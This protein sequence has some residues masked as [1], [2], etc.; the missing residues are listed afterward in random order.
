MLLQIAA[1]VPLLLHTEPMLADGGT[2]EV[3]AARPTSSAAESV[4]ERDVIDAAPRGGGAVDVLRLV[5]GLVAS[6]HSGDG[7][8]HQLFLRGFDA[9]HGQDVEL[10]AAGMP[11]NAVSHLHA[12]GYA[13]A[14]FLIPEAVQRVRVTEGTYR[15]FQGDFA[16]AGT[17]SFE[18]GLSEPGAFA[19][20]T[21]GTYGQRRLLL[22]ARAP[23]DPG[24]FIAAEVSQT[25]GYGERRG[26]R[27]YSAMAQGK[28]RF[29]AVTLRG[30][31]GSYQSEFESP[32]VVRATELEAGRAG[33]FDARFDFQ[34]GRTARHQGL[35]GAD[36][37]IAGGRTSLELCGAY[38][39]DVIRN[40]FTG[41]LAHP[42]GDGREQ[43]H[44]AGTAVLRL[45]HHR[46][47]QLLGASLSIDGS[48]GARGD[49]A[50]QLQHRYRESDGAPADPQ[51]DARFRQGDAWGWLEFKY[52]PGAWELFLGGRL[53][54]LGFAVDD[55]LAVKG[56]G[57]RR[58]SLGVHPGL[59]AGLSR[60]FG[61][62]LRLLANYGDGFRSPQALSLGEGERAPFVTARSAELGAQWRSERLDANLTAFGSYVDDDV[63]FDPALGTTA[64][65]GPSW[66]AGGTASVV[67]RPVGE[68]VIA[69]SITGATARR[70]RPDS[71]LPYFAPLVARADVGDGLQVAPWLHLRGGLGLTLIG[72]RP[73]PYDEW[74]FAVFLADALLAARVGAVEVRAEV[75]NLFDSRWRDGEFVFASRYASGAAASLLPV[76]HF[77]AGAPRQFSLTMEL[78]L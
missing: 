47:T 72:P 56:D 1:F 12:Q 5:P 2:T 50:R 7:K 66:R 36:F 49:T 65:T 25:D 27:R 76:R 43:L 15:A 64:F 3:R 33:F 42:D 34:G 77:S 32:G 44:Q 68:L 13:D 41:F 10:M 38:T 45:T 11:L 4:V 23:F 48:L 20:S 63:V 70:A 28:H 22:G 24:T 8:A 51:V 69:A 40:N 37:D 59:K 16:V 9:V 14:N 75:H 46:R 31:V 71:L 74:S 54:V 61:E 6:Q 19:S 78:H 35:V 26:S 67:T 18:L 30:F 21:V 55:A 52:H 17:V 53:D 58:T 57:D 29:G 73:L 39:S 60:G 62:H